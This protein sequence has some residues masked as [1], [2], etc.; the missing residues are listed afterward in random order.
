MW[1]GTCYPYALLLLHAGLKFLKKNRCQFETDLKVAYMDVYAKY[2]LN[3]KRMLPAC[4]LS[5][6]YHP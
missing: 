1:A 4:Y 5:I 6:M 2:R 3:I